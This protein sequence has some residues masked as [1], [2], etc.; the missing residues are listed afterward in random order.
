MSQDEGPAEPHQ[1]SSKW[2]IYDKRNGSDLS[3]PELSPVLHIKGA[4]LIHFRRRRDQPLQ[5][6]PFS[7]LDRQPAVINA[8]SLRSI[9]A[10]LANS[11][12]ENMRVCDTFSVV[13]AYC[14]VKS[15]QK[16]QSLSTIWNH[17]KICKDMWSPESFSFCHVRHLQYQSSNA[18]RDDGEIWGASARIPCRGGWWMPS[19]VCFPLWISKEIISKSKPRCLF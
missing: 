5:L 6:F 18:Q 10:M 19:S 14:W 1:T 13:C 16:S 15:E 8:G 2:N 11:D 9:G 3:P 12:G 7:T 4:D 17:V